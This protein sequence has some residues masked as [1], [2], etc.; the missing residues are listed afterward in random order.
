ME[1]EASYFGGYNGYGAPLGRIQ[2]NRHEEDEADDYQFYPPFDLT[3]FNLAL[4]GQ[5]ITLVPST[6]NGRLHPSFT[7]QVPA[8]GIEGLQQ[9]DGSANDIS[10]AVFDGDPYI[11]GELL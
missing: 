3:R 8:P 6:F 10:H 5:F 2:T 1:R 11:G 9:N 7:T 4:P